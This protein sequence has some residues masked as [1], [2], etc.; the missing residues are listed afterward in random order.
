MEKWVKCVLML[1]WK[2][3]SFIASPPPPPN[4]N[5]FYVFPVFSVVGIMYPL[6]TW[7]SCRIRL[8]ILE[9]E[10]VYPYKNFFGFLQ[11]RPS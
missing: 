2:W 3:T 9:E 1:I 5:M 8:E 11:E 6:I 7:T 4:W 10:M